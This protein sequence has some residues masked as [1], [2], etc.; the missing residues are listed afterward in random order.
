M[1]G[2]HTVSV[3]RREWRF[4]MRLLVRKGRETALVTPGGALYWCEAAV[5]AATALRENK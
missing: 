4:N 2:L 3:E 1:K 5:V